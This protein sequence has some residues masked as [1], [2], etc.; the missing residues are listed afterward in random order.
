MILALSSSLS[1]AAEEPRLRFPVDCNLGDSC[2]LMNL[3]D[4]EPDK[5]KALDFLCGTRTYDGHDGTDIAIRDEG[6]IKKGIPVLAA[7]GGT[8]TKLRDG[9]ED[10]FLNVTEQA[11]IKKA[12]KECGNGIFIEHNADWSTQYCH[13]R[14][15]SLKVKQGDKVEAG[16]EIAEVGLSGISDHPHLH[17]TVRHKGEA[18]DPFTGAE[19][20]SGCGQHRS[21]ILTSLWA[22]R[23]DTSGFN[24]YDGGLTGQ[25]PDFGQ[26]SQGKKPVSLVFK[27]HQILFWFV[28][29]A[30][31]KGDR[32]DLSIT[33]PSGRILADYQTVQDKNK[34]RQYLYTG[35]KLPK[36]LPEKGVYK[37]EARVTR[38]SETGETRTEI[39]SREMEIK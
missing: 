4:T 12:G 28:Y 15:N 39:L 19:V 24:L 13:L 9:V 10:K 31:Q 34:A 20:K 33:S 37:G 21:K 14:K 23:V 8:V 22:E 16:Q 1:H 17:L 38:V 29:F 36:G 6:E 35:Q 3:P 27:D 5:D 25:A 18:V 26:I 30:A 7:Q 2:W 32:I 11:D